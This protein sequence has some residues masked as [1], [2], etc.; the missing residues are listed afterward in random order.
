M[1]YERL[2]D[3]KLTSYERSVHAVYLTWKKN[4]TT[5][6]ITMNAVTNLIKVTFVPK[7][8]FMPLVL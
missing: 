4:L 5:L 2:M 7:F 6:S 8:N 1:S 3:A